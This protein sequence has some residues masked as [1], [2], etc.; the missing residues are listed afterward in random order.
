MIWSRSAAEGVA[1]VVERFRPDVAH[2]HNIYHQLSPSVLSAL[3]HFQ[4]PM[5]MTLHDYKLVCPTYLLLDKGQVCEACLD[6]RFRHA[7]QR[8]C[9]DGSLAASALLAGESAIHRSIK[10]YSPV[11]A[12]ICP[13]RFMQRKMTQANVFPDRLRYL[14]HFVD[15]PPLTAQVAP[16]AHV[17]FA[18]RLS[19]EKGAD[20][21]VR[22]A[23]KLNQDTRVL[24]AGDGPDRRM[25]EDLSAE[26]APGRVK[27]LGR[28]AKDELELY[29]RSSAVVVVPSRCH[30][31]QP[32]TIL[33][34]FRVGIPVIG[35]AL[36][37]I[38]E[39]IDHGV[40][41][42]VVP[43]NDP[44]ELAATLDGVLADNERSRS[45]GRAGQEKVHQ[46]FSPA[47]H[48]AALHQIYEEAATRRG[49][50]CVSP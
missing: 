25:L 33:E 13:S 44:N 49:L 38:P 40:D 19:P 36:G 5:V 46:R 34:A 39:L 4:V 20:V 22:A 42:L 2:L 3:R 7:I 24:I 8:R 9:K 18:G 12:F 29:I 1:A 32:M 45:M 48:L 47:A 21:L 11:Q 28:L 37:G 6:G 10:A 50:T 23:G 31:N 15:E 43:P 41:G 27:L 35:T 14:P 16:G 26:V 17:L 30:E